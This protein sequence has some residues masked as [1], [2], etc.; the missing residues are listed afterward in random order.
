MTSQKRKTQIKIRLS[1]PEH[2]ALKDASSP[3]PL[4]SW[5]REVSLRES[6]KIH[7]QR[8]QNPKLKVDPDLLRKLSGIGNNINQIARALNTIEISAASKVEALALL[9]GIYKEVK[10]I[11]R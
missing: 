2:Q 9:N 5:I 7:D 11:D 6:S 4:A 8:I 10:K 3:K 1:E